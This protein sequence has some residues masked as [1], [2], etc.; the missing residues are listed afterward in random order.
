MKLFHCR[1]VAIAELI[2]NVDHHDAWT[3]GLDF[4]IGKLH[5]NSLLASLITREYLRSKA[6]GAALDL[7][8]NAVHFTSLP[9]LSEDGVSENDG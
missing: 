3:M 9:K 6:S 4:I 5:T 7:R 8:K 1:L 2:V